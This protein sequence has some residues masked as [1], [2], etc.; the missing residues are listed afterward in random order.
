MEEI[1]NLFVSCEPKAK[2]RARTISK[3]GRTW[4]YSPKTTVDAE[5]AI[6]S[7]TYEYMKENHMPYIT[8][9]MVVE[10]VFHMPIQKSKVKQI[11]NTSPH[12]Q[13]PDI[14]NLMKLVLDALNEVAYE[15]DR[16]IHTVKGKKMYSNTPGIRISIK[17]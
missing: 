15:D 10:M 2:A 13:K 9:P 7:K 5:N 3:N 17:C 12:L 4:S 14:D 1:L 8:K 6:K 16:L 11:L